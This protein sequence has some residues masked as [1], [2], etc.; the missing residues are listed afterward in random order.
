MKN[1]GDT[2]KYENELYKIIDLYSKRVKSLGLRIGG[3]SSKTKITLTLK[4]N[5]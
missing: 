5:Q 2:V 4:V 1:I 3:G